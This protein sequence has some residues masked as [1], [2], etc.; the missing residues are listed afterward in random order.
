M[1]L[2]VIQYYTKNANSKVWTVILGWVLTIFYGILSIEWNAIGGYIFWNGGEQPCASI[3]NY[4][5]SHLIINFVAV[6]V[7][8]VI[9]HV[10]RG[11]NYRETP[12]EEEK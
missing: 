7:N 4:L 6:P 5:Y 9:L 3:S 1:W 2:G 12:E 10:F 11:S 8:L